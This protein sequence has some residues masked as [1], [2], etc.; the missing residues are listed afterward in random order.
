MATEVMAG[1]RH[2]A[3]QGV[4]S[5]A[6]D[7]RSPIRPRE[8]KDRHGAHGASRLG[9]SRYRADHWRG[10]YRSQATKADWEEE[11]EEV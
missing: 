10:P 8:R 7:A 9:K 11:L 6:G 4:R 2:A 3:S 5:E 1:Q